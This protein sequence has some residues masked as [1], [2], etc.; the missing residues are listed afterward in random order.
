MTTDLVSAYD[1]ILCNESLN[2]LSQAL[3]PADANRLIIGLGVPNATREHNH[4]NHQN[5]VV[6]ANYE[7]LRYWR[8]QRRSQRQEHEASNQHLFED[9][10]SE[11]DACGRKDINVWIKQTLEKDKKL[12]QRDF[13]HY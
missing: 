10:L 9:L 5:D 3:T 7:S 4:K 8:N 13:K 11:L 6:T 2:T 1:K 12:E